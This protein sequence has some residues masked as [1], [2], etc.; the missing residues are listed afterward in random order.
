MNNI[1][2]VTKKKIIKGDKKEIQPQPCKPVYG[3]Q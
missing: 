2:Q 1:Q 3:G